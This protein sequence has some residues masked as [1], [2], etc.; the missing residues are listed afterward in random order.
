MASNLKFNITLT[1]AV[2]NTW[3]FGASFNRWYDEF[4]FRISFYRWIIAIGRFGE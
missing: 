4:Y 3:S 2:N 1:K